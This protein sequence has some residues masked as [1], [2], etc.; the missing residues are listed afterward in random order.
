MPLFSVDTQAVADTAAR[1]RA[2]VATIQAEVDAMNGD[3]A[4][5]QASWTGGASASMASCAADWH[6]TQ[7]QVQTSLDAISQAL[8]AS[9]LAYDEAESTNVSRF[10]AQ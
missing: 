6:L 2:R 10:G 8:D 4:T 1:A 3:I 7:V 5:L 9:A